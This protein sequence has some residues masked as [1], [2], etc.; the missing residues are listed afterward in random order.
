LV[1]LFIV[2]VCGNRL[3]LPTEL[4]PGINR[5]KITEAIKQK[6]PSVRVVE[7]VDERMHD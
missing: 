7:R 1:E 6:M 5:E 2:D 4:F 3:A